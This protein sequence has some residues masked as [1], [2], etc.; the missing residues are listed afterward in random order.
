MGIVNISSDFEEDLSK[1][2]IFKMGF[3]CIII[4]I[5]YN[6]LNILIYYS[7]QSVRFNFISILIN[8]CLGIIL[9]LAIYNTAIIFDLKIGEYAGISKIIFD[10]AKVSINLYYNSYLGDLFNSYTF[11]III[12]VQDVLIKQILIFQLISLIR[13]VLIDILDLGI[14]GLN[15]ISLIL[16]SNYFY[17]LGRTKNNFY[18]K[19]TSIAFIISL[20][21]VIFYSFVPFAVFYLCS[22]L[23]EHLFLAISFNIFLTVKIKYIEQLNSNYRPIRTE[24]K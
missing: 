24:Y 11:F 6:I 18:F 20:I 19:M 3:V 4:I 10:F 14:I 22:I 23:L 5:I 8:S 9:G 15:L 2:S 1:N 16:I 21:L 17:N 7:S 13:P 12:L